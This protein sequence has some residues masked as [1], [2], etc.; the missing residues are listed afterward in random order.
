M[1]VGSAVQGIS[2]LARA[3]LIAATLGPTGF[4]VYGLLSA[5]M[6]TV[7]LMGSMGQDTA[8]PRRIAQSENEAD[9]LG[10]SRAVWA[11]IV[12]VGALAALSGAVF[13]LFHRQIAILFKTPQTEVAWLSLGVVLGIAAIIPIA[14]LQ[15]LRRIDRLARLHIEAGIASLIIGGAAIV[16]FGRAGIVISMVIAPACLMISGLYAVTKVLR[17]QTLARP[18]GVSSAVLDLVLR[19]GPLMVA[20]AL[21][22]G[23]GLAARGIIQHFL[24]ATSLGLYTAAT[25][26]GMTYIPLLLNALGADY[27]PRL[28]ALVHRPSEASQL[29]SEQTEIGILIIIP[30]ALGII[31]L[32]PWLMIVLFSAEF[33]PGAL[34]LQFLV[35]ADILR[36]AA[37]PLGFVLL[38]RGEGWMLIGIDLCAHS[39]FLALTLIAA[40]QYGVLA[41]GAAFPLAT[42]LSAGLM[43][44]VVKKRIPLLLGR[45]LILLLAS[46]FGIASVTI[47]ISTQHAVLGAVFGL[48][49]AIFFGAFSIVRLARLT[50]AEGWLRLLSEPVRRLLQRAGMV[51]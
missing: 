16:L 23:T 9:E 5:L 46:G 26:L 2:G 39:A 47:A 11:L 24:G 8:G 12:L 4:G 25:T 30:V 18:S 34:L 13:L 21:L 48:S 42:V 43:C 15:G 19:G 31:S 49:A 14:I 44:F 36:V 32:A 40:E 45:V 33:R 6:Q 3:K 35:A 38:A 1:G 17:G 22:I 41:T 20:G 10:L 28:S 37:W 7:V 29:V 50:E 51:I 27:L